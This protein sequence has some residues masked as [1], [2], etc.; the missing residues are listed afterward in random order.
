M[1]KKEF[2]KEHTNILNEKL[3]KLRCLELD[4]EVFQSEYVF[5][6]KIKDTVLLIKDITNSFYI[7]IHKDKDLIKVKNK[8]VSIISDINSV[9]TS[10]KNL[11][12]KVVRRIDM[13]YEV[14]KNHPDI[15][16]TPENYKEYFELLK[17]NINSNLSKEIKS[18]KLNQNSRVSASISVKDSGEEFGLS[19]YSSYSFS[20]SISMDI[21]IEEIKEFEEFAFIFNNKA[22]KFMKLKTKQAYLKSIKKPEKIEETI[23]EEVGI[24]NLTNPSL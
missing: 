8:K 20:S 7:A 14:Y 22:L 21:D 5:D 24:E 13:I 3:N 2:I 10:I 1:N 23:E 17:E 6:E 18:T 9:K 19:K 11:K 12:E 4:K 15:P 16:A